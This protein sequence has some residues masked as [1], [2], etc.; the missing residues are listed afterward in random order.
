MTTVSL[1]SRIKSEWDMDSMVGVNIW[2][3][4]NI[5]MILADTESVGKVSK[6]KPTQMSQESKGDGSDNDDSSYSPS[7]GSDSE[8]EGEYVASQ[9]DVEN[10]ALEF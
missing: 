6:S 3:R 1:E 9:R 4:E 8:E 7:D 10:V 5:P 2:G